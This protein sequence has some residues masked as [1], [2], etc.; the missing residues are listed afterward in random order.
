MKSDS[1][2][3]AMLIKEIYSSTVGA[4]SCGLKEIGLTHQQIMVIKLIAHNKKVNI[5]ELCEEMS[6]SKGTVSGIVTR[7]ESLGYVK[8]IKLENDKRNTYVTFSDKGLEFAKEYKN[9][10]N[11]SFDKVF[12]NLTEEEIKEVKSSLLKLRDKIKEN[13]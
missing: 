6:L 2:E 1:F 11:E 5:S 9:K 12:K 8:K 4:V 13:D 10:I 7:L 3:I